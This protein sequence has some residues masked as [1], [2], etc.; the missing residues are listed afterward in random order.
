VGS[1]GGGCVESCGEGVHRV[2][3]AGKECGGYGHASSGCGGAGMC[4][5]DG[6]LNGLRC[7]LNLGGRLGG[8]RSLSELAFKLSEAALF[9]IVEPRLRRG[10]SKR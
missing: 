5:C 3:H 8:G 1:I 9:A 6:L 10:W 2:D 7:S 4:S